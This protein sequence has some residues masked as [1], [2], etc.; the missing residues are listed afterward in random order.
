MN[1]APEIQGKRGRITQSVSSHSTVALMSHRFTGFS[2][3]ALL[4]LG[5]IPGVAWLLFDRSVWS[6]DQSAYGALSV[7]LF[8]APLS[9]PYAWLRLMFGI[10]Q[11]APG[12][13]WLGQLFVPVGIA[14]GSINAGLLGSVLAVQTVTI[15]LLFLSIRTLGDGQLLPAAVGAF[16]MASAPLFV[17]ESHQ[18][19][20]EPLQT[21]SVA[22][23]IF[24]LARARERDGLQTAAHL[25]AASSV[26][27]MAKISTPLYVLLPGAIVVLILISRPAMFMRDVR[28]TVRRVTG[29]VA[30]VAVSF[31]AVLWYARSF[32]TITRFAVST[33]VGS[34]GEL[35][36]E[37]PRSDA[38]RLLD[39]LH[40]ALGSY[41]VP[42]VAVVLLLIV[43]LA[44]V[45]RAR[46]HDVR[47]SVR[48]LGFFDLCA[49]AAALQILGVLGVFS[50]QVLTDWRFLLPLLPY[51]ALLVAWV[52]YRLNVAWLPRLLLVVLLVQWFV[53]QAQA[54]GVV[55]LISG[56]T[57][58]LQPFDSA[59]RDAADLN[60]VV[61]LTCAADQASHVGMVGVELP[62]FN[63]NSLD[64]AAAKLQKQIG[65]RCH[66]TTWLLAESRASDAWQRLSDVNADYFI[67]LQ[68]QLY[69]PASDRFNIVARPLL[70]MVQSS[71]LYRRVNLVG[72]PRVVVFQRIR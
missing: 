68:P 44:A 20:V 57:S 40:A 43:I 26:A 8:Y 16:F 29:L 50:Q 53:V 21:L 58:W 23:F 38:A 9:S 42:P 61:R 49:A 41:F 14:V 19:M 60:A 17:G 24:I 45:A 46:R 1:V 54:F 52:S 34:I 69:P 37:A 28:F 6:F 65:A 47:I 27:L 32:Q 10:W 15:V 67:T 7:D 18:Y 5:Q 35:Y 31:A 64:F 25:L 62:W 11:K 36:N 56:V 70:Q 2:L 51:P 12:I 13:A 3:G 66:Y 72:H 39:W 71:P 33:T 48:Q 59:S 22:W 30:A 55:P 4:V 63:H